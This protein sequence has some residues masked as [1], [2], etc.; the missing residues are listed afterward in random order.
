[1]K[2]NLADD[3]IMSEF[4]D[5]VGKYKYNI[6]YCNCFSKIILSS[7]RSHFDRYFHDLLDLSPDQ[8]EQLMNSTSLISE[9]IKAKSVLISLKELHTITDTITKHPDNFSNKNLLALSNRFNI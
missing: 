5:L 9:R 7:K 1:M 3:A 2:G 6:K 8:I 4:N